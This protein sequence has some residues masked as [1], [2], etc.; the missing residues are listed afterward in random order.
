MLNSLSN[1]FVFLI[2]NT[3]NFPN[4]PL[5]YALYDYSLLELWIVVTP[6]DTS[7]FLVP[8]MYNRPL[9]KCGL[10]IIVL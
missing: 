2:C 8:A 5:H 9:N 1:P 3:L 4:S 10:V 6:K 7:I